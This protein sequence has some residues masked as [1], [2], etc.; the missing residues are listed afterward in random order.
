LK[1]DGTV[2]M[3]V[4]NDK[5]Q[6]NTGSWRGIV[7]IAAGGT[8]TV[9]LKADGTVVAVR[10]NDHG[11]C[12]IGNWRDIVAISAGAWCTAGLKADGK[13]FAVGDNGHGQCNTESWRD[14]V[15]IAAGQSHSVGLK[16]DGTIVVV[17]KYM[18]FNKGS[19]ECNFFEF[20]VSGWRDIGPIPEELVCKWKGICKYCGGKLGGL[21][22][23]KC[24]ACGRE[25]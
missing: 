3:V 13:V 2:V 18:V 1:A 22:S 5:G 20:D 25:N 15:A 24:K 9:G 6:Y 11:Q 19:I 16:A 4:D 7:A 17:G 12:N 21:F 8:H 10:F 14:I 23:K